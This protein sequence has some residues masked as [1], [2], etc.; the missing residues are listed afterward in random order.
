[1][2]RRP[3]RLIY[4]Y[5]SRQPITFTP[6]GPRPAGS[7]STV[8]SR[9]TG[10]ARRVRHR[11]TRGRH[12]FPA[13]VAA[14]VTAVQVG[15]VDG[16]SGDCLQGECRWEDVAAGGHHFGHLAPVHVHVSCGDNVNV[17]TLPH[18]SYSS[19]PPAWYFA[20]KINFDWFFS[21]KS[22][23]WTLAAVYCDNSK[24]KRAN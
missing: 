14:A 24:R 13:A 15:A 20:F 2:R 4:N 17:V 6:A 1:M 12:V 9:R 18:T 8:T 21:S 23:T 16:G 22:T 7:S 5:L 19:T 3:D 11:D 10:D